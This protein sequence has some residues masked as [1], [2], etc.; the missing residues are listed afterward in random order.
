MQLDRALARLGEKK[1]EVVSAPENPY[2]KGTAATNTAYKIGDRY[3]YR[4]FDT[5]FKV[6]GKPFTQVVTNITENEV[7]Y[8]KG[9]RVTD[10]LGNNRKLGPNIWSANQ[11]VPTEFIV[12]KRW[13]TR[14]HLIEAS[15]RD[16]VVNLELR[17]ADR[18]KITV[19]AGTFNAFR[20]EARGWRTG[21]G[22]NVSWNW[23][24][25]Y[26]PDQVRAEVASEWLFMTSGLKTL[27]SERREL[28]AFRQS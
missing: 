18:E 21:S 8:S 20:I 16:T 4:R 5:M 11:T 15:G 17:V 10:L 14:F 19:P 7:I 26:A 24:T 12:G 3:T 28:T 27:F 22:V 23:K 13:N 6:E 25:W 9:G 1:V 2:S